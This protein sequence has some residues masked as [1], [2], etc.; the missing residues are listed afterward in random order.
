[1]WK[2]WQPAELL[3]PGGL[4]PIRRPTDRLGQSGS[5]PRCSVQGAPAPLRRPTAIVGQS[6]SPPRCSALGA[7]LPVRGP[8]ASVGQSGS[9]PLCSALAAPPHSGGRPP[10]W[11]KEAARRPAQPCRPP[12]T[13]AAHRHSGKKWQPA[14]LHIT[15]GPPQPL[16]RPTAIVGRRGRAPRCSVLGAPAPLRRPTARVGQSGSPPRCSA[17]GAPS[18]L[19]RPTTT[20]R[21]SV[22]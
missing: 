1:M 12:P 11:V 15:G 10:G 22:V 3:S 18:P 9:P 6:G 4:P 5:P 19:M 16:R 2:N 20:D 8:T 17:L 13:Q 21:K 7:L 14:A